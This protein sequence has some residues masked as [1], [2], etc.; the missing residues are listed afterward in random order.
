MNNSQQKTHVLHNLDGKKIVEV[1]TI[2]F[3]AIVFVGALILG[4]GT[5][6]GVAQFMPTAGG[7]ADS[8]GADATQ[9]DA[10][11]NKTSAGIKDKE[12]FNDTATGLLK[13]GGFE[14]EGSFHLERPG[15]TDQNVYMTSSTVDLSEFMGKKVTV[16]GKTFDSKKAGWLMDVGYIEISK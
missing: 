10:S 12:T 14:G 8:A 13:E 7:S 5:G 6:F 4:G 3:I 9:L 2:P 15:G 16:W 1:A 11:G